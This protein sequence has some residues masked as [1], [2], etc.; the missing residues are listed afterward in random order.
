[1][2]D[3][4]STLVRAR[5]KRYNHGG[6]STIASIK[7]SETHSKARFFTCGVS[8]LRQ[9]LRRQDEFRAGMRGWAE[10]ADAW[11]S[12]CAILCQNGCHFGH[13]QVYKWKPE[14]VARA[15]G[16]GLVIKGCFSLFRSLT[17]S[18][19]RQLTRERW[20]GITGWMIQ[21]HWLTHKVSHLSPGYFP[22]SGMSETALLLYLWGMISVA[23]PLAKP[24]QLPHGCL[25]CG[26]SPDAEK[27]A[28]SVYRKF[29]CSEPQSQNSK[30][31]REEDFQ[32]GHVTKLWI[33]IDFAAWNSTMDLRYPDD[34]LRA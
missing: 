30:T 9:V 19:E 14:A 7:I 34:I 22:C 8:S 1:M 31:Q 3:T 27:P 24:Q 21:R 18:E 12:T 32:L 23:R 15:Q 26:M 13:L 2:V 33:L 20:Q 4:A 28:V 5:S 6:S 10:D 11:S 17:K 25:L 16:H 29:I